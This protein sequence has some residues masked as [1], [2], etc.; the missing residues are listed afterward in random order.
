[1]NPSWWTRLCDAVS[2]RCRRCPPHLRGRVPVDCGVGTLQASVWNGLRTL[3]PPS[4]PLERSVR[5]FS[6]GVGWT[7]YPDSDMHRPEHMRDMRYLDGTTRAERL[8]MLHRNATRAPTV[9]EAEAIRADHANLQ[10]PSYEAAFASACNKAERA[11]DAGEDVAHVT[12][13]EY[14]AVHFT[15]AMRYDPSPTRGPTALMLA[16]PH[17]M[18]RLEVAKPAPAENAR[19]HSKEGGTW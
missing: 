17:G 6:P 9:F 13:D 4:A 5:A 14:T 15:V 3:T 7:T 10:R 11:A 18:V 16:T 19:R 1:M 8:A 2:A 12:P